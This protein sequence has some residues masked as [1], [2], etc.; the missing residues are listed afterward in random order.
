M[1]GKTYNVDIPGYATWHFAR[2][3]RH[4]SAKRD[5]GGFL[6]LIKETFCEYATISHTSEYVV[7]LTLKDATSSLIHIGFVYV[8]PVYSTAHMDTEPFDELQNQIEMKRTT[9]RVFIT[10]RGPKLPHR[11][12]E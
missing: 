2:E 10:G 9:G 6:L 4:E 7:W 3:S 12:A 1:K 5:A 8:P 11:R